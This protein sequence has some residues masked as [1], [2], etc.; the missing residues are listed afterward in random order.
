MYV[1]KYVRTYVLMYP[2]SSYKLAKVKAYTLHGKRRQKV[3]KVNTLDVI[4]IITSGYKMCVPIINSLHTKC[5]KA[6]LSANH[7]SIS[8]VP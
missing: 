7:L 4:Q 3:D 6:K 5:S 8:C 1:C 2:F